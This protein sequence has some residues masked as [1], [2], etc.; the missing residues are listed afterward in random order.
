M[1][2]DVKKKEENQEQERALMNQV[3]WNE[4]VIVETIEFHSEQQTASIPEQKVPVAETYTQNDLLKKINEN[5]K[6]ALQAA[7]EQNYN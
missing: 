3:E 2:I 5:K 6:L 7:E 4:F 1:R